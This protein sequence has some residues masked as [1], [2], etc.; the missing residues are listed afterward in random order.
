MLDAGSGCGYGANYLAEKGAASVTGID[1]SRQR[2][3]AAN[4]IFDEEICATRRW[5]YRIS[6]DSRQKHL[7]LFLPQMFWSILQMFQPSYIPLINF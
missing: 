2:L 4:N 1:F 3:L 6:K 7:I 5:I